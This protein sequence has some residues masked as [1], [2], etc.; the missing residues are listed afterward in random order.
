[1]KMRMRKR[2]I[3][4]VGIFVLSASTIF[5][6]E[7]TD[8]KESKDDSQINSIKELSENV[9]RYSKDGSLNNQE[10]ELIVTKTDSETIVNYIENSMD[11]V[12]RE[13]NARKPDSS[14][15]IPT[16]DKTIETWNIKVD[17]LLSTK[18]SIEDQ[19]DTSF[20]EKIVKPIS[21]SICPQALASGDD[22]EFAAT[23]GEKVWKNY[24]NRYFTAK[25]VWYIGTGYATMRTEN[26][27]NLSSVGI[28][29]RYA[30]T[31]VNDSFGFSNISLTQNT[32]SIEDQ[33]A[34]SPGKSDCHIKSRVTFKYSFK[35]IA[36]AYGTY[37]IRTTCGF[38]DIDKA[39]KKIRVKQSWKKL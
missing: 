6:A 10:K 24:G 8:K 20:L 12:S 21:N 11:K 30:T 5:A 14:V 27:Y 16:E 22:F 2:V 29:E 26:H 37:Y 17:E 9:E 25:Y 19:E 4:L 7:P 39:K 36:T 18:V 34:K 3:I 33:W 23:Q 13:V 1:M 35:G 28:K 32:Y 15:Y 38:N 31:W